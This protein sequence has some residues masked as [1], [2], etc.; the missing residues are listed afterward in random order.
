MSENQIAAIV[1]FI[2]SQAISCIGTFFL[3]RG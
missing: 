3:W 1:L 2:I